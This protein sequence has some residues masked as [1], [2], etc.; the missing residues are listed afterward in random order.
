MAKTS[1]KYFKCPKCKKES[2]LRKVKID[3]DGV[4]VK[5]FHCINYI[6]GFK[7]NHENTKQILKDGT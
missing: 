3:F 7:V 2:I 6:C 4:N 5:W 1:N